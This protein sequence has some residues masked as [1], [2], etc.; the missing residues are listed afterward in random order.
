MK[1]IEDDPTI[2]RIREVRHQIS[3]SFDHDPRKLVAHYIEFQKQYADRL[4]KRTLKTESTEI[5][6][7][8]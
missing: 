5:V 4:V 7:K 3:A 1:K 6:T 2:K 8:S